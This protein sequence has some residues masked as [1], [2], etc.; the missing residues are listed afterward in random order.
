VVEE[1]QRYY[2]SEA[3]QRDKAFWQA[4]RKALP[5]PASLS[6]PAGGAG[7]Q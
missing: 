5:S 7:D 4:Q 2:G 6:A 1:Y 3:W